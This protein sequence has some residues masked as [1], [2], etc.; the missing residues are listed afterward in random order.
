M[1]DWPDGMPDADWV[2]PDGAIR[3]HCADCLDVLPT[4]PDGCVDAVVT[5]PPYNVGIDYGEHDDNMT[6]AQFAE[7]A[8]KWFRECR[9]I[10]KTV[11]ITGQGRLPQYAII[12]PWKWLLQWWKPAAMGRSPVGFNEWEPIAMWG[13]GSSAGSPDV[14]R[15]CIIPQ[16]DTGDHPCPKPLYWAI[17]QVERFPK[18]DAFADPF[19]GTGTVG[20]ACVRL[21]RRFIGIELEPK[22]FDIAVNRIEK[23]LAN[24][25]LFTG[26]IA[27]AESPKLIEV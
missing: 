9:R 12:E 27:P 24:D 22:Y 11:L 19:T 16:T 5:D 2:S 14:I 20:V 10:S 25:G 8:G 4:L 18:H 26:H 15:A 3:L 1:T 6:V 17:G 23:E 13:N 21:N 7:W